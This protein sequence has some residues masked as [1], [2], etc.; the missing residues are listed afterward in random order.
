[1]VLKK[2]L[3]IITLLTLF[4]GTWGCEKYTTGNTNSSTTKPTYTGTVVYVSEYQTSGYYTT[5]EMS[6]SSVSG[7]L[8]YKHNIG[9]YITVQFN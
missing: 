8:S 6:N 2:I 5:L 1:M 4:I 7:Y 3:I 9:D